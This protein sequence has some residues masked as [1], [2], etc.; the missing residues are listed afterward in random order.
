MATKSGTQKNVRKGGSE[1][2][3]AF[4][5]SVPV[6]HALDRLFSVLVFVAAMVGLVVLAVLLVDIDWDGLPRLGWGF[7]NNLPSVLPQN[8]GIYP[9]FLEIGRASCRGRV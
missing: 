2:E 3:A 1:G 8:S 4:K 5:S 7:L 6:R 9:A